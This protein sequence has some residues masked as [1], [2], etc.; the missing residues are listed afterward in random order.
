MRQISFVIGTNV[1]LLAA[2]ILYFLTAAKVLVPP[3]PV[4]FPMLEEFR[5]GRILKKRVL[6]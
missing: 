4:E 6:E 1:V 5:R 2:C 3:S